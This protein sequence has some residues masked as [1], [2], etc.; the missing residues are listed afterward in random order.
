MV[1]GRN[2]IISLVRGDKNES[3]RSEIGNW[4]FVEL[5]PEGEE[6]KRVWS[7]RKADTDSLVRWEMHCSPEPITSV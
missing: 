2:M 5:D 1:S 7:I 3:C 4:L 6:G